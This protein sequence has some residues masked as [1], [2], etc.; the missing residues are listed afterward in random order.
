MFTKCLGSKVVQ[1]ELMVGNTYDFTW[2]ILISAVYIAAT[3]F[4][5]E[6]SY[7]QV[8]QKARDNGLETIL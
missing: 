6:N 1:D 8:V 2:K 3:T 5:R 4:E 7:S